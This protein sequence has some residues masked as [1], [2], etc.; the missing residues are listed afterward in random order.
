MKQRKKLL[1]AILEAGSPWRQQDGMMP[2]IYC[3]FFIGILYISSAHFVEKRMR[4]IQA[5]KGE[6]KELRWEYMT[7]KSDLM[8]SS[9]YS[10][11][12]GAVNSSEQLKSSSIPK[13]I[14]VRG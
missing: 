8:F 5:L 14:H 3:L 4:N 11:V 13:R 9:T 12:L 2:I 7:V 1:K 6:L 10:Q